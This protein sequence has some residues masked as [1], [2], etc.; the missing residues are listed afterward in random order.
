[1][2]I[3]GSAEIMSV[4]IW[5]SMKEQP[6][7]V[8][9]L[10]GIPLVKAVDVIAQSIIQGSPVGSVVLEERVMPKTQGKVS[11]NIADAIKN[12]AIDMDID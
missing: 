12:W 10:Q 4:D 2:E 1:M 6:D 11:Q 8:V 7:I 9:E 5:N 3:G